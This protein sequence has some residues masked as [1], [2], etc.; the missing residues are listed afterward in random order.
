MER[1]LQD[2]LVEKCAVFGVYTKHSRASQLVYTGL[3]ALQHR[4][5]DASGIS[6]TDGKEI[7]THKALGLVA[8]V[9]QETDV[10][11][12]NGYIAIG[13]NRYSTSGGVEGHIQPI[14][15]EQGLLALAHNGTLPIR[16]ELTTFLKSKDIPASQLMK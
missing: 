16:I 14:T 1:D 4:G 13:H 6:S 5:Q 3:W 2:R 9:Y 11:R 8:S 12:L 7:Y 15:S 10:D